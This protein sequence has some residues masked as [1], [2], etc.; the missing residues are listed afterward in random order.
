MNTKPT[1][2]QIRHFIKEYVESRKGTINNLSNETFK[3][4]Y[5]DKPASEEFTYNFALSKEKKIPLIAIGSQTFQQILHNCLEEG[6]LSQV[7]LKPKDPAALIS[8]HFKEGS[9]A[10]IDCEKVHLEKE[11]VNICVKNQPCC[12]LVNNGKITSVNIV[13]KEPVRFFKFYFSANFQNKLRSK[14]QEIITL[15]VNEKFNVLRVSEYSDEIFQNDC[16]ISIEDYKSKLKVDIFEKLKAVVDERMDNLLREKLVLFDLPL[17]KDKKAKLQS[18]DKRLSRERREHAISKKIDFDFPKWQ[19][20]YEALLKREEESYITHI[21]VKFL[22]LLII[23]TFK[24]KFEVNLDNNSTI[25][26]SLM[27]GINHNVE[28][29]CPICRKTFSEGYATYDE[30]YVCADCIRQSIETQ[31]IYSK[32]AT[33]TIDETLKEYIESDS[34]F[35]CS[36]CGKKHSRL[37]EFKCSHDNSSVCINH[38]GLC[39]VCGKVFS[40]I[41]LKYTAEFRGQLCPKHAQHKTET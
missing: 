27:L 31:K 32:K 11:T 8:R 41:N 10:C 36:V 14:N 29:T 24:I 30:Q 33:L 18:F 21:T 22:N 25:H 28:V 13:K 9:F 37:L 26:S 19:A 2:I 39:S 23:N 16:T 6:V 15:L 17:Y 5:Q 40:K 12:H 34:G 38:Y 35:I 3:V 7:L 1:D 20:N 4:T